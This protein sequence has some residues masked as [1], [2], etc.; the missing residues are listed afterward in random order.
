MPTRFRHRLL[1]FTKPAVPGK[2]KTRLARSIGEQRA[3]E[4]HAAFVDDV[5]SALGTGRFERHVLWAPVD[6]RPEPPEL[7]GW[8]GKWQRGN[9][10]GERLFNA[11]TDAVDADTVGVA[12]VGSDHPGLDAERVEAAFRHLD[13]GADVV[14]GPATDGGYYL[15]ALTPEALDRRLF[16]DIAWSTETVAETTLQRCETLGLTVEKLSEGRDVDDL[17]DLEALAHR[18]AVDASDARCPRTRA[19]LIAW[20]YLN[21]QGSACAS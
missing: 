10:L 15:L 5:S 21:A 19:H 18:L 9:D 4:L 12:V 16:T 11:L 14:L 1:L 8:L 2:V 17:A 3:A 7:P 20:G 6:D 13:Q